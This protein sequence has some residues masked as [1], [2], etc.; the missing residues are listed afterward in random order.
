MRR[1]Q[2]RD[3]VGLGRGQQAPGLV[4]GDLGEVP[5]MAPAERGRA[6][7]EPVQ[8]E[9]ANGLQQPVPRLVCGGL[10]HQQRV[11]D[12]C[13]QPP[14]H[15]VRWHVG[16][17]DGDGVIHG[18]SAGQ[19]AETWQQ[20]ARAVRQQLVRPADRHVERGLTPVPAHRR[21]GVGVG[22]QRRLDLG[23]REVAQAGRGQLQGE[24][25]SVQAA[26]QVDDGPGVG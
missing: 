2:L 3:R 9:D 1:G 22:P 12:Q 16:R 14:T 8:G 4:L 11:L 24:G 6:T 26:A 7:P 18:E 10:R 15:Q 19:D 13:G 25:Q 20:L 21:R 17:A 23:G 5:C